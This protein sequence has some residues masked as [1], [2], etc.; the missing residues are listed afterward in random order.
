MLTLIVEVIRGADLDVSA[1]IDGSAVAI[2]G[3]TGTLGQALVT[4]LL[5]YRLNKIVIIS[6]S[7]SRQAAMKERWPESNDSPMRY[8][9]R[10]IRDKAGLLD[11]FEGVQIV[12]HAAALKRVEVCEREPIESLQTNVIGTLNACE[13]A[14]ECGVE[15]FM[16]ISSDKATAAA[17]YYG[18]LKYV[19]ERLVCLFNNYRGK[20]AIRYSACR[21]G[22]VLGST[23][24]V[25]HAFQNGNGVVQITDERCTRFWI[26]PEQAAKFV[27]S[28]IALSKGGE[29]FVP[30]M[31][32]MAIKDMARIIAPQSKVM[33][34]GL[35]GAEKIH[36]CLYSSEE[37][38]WVV[39]LE[40]R[41]VLLPPMP[42]WGGSLW[43][44]AK[45]VVEGSAYT[46]QNAPKL[47]KT[48]FLGMVNA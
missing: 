18:G 23:G 45:P 19:A 36:E 12:I 29:V 44:G 24:S 40:D 16:F 26:T 31:K 22:N 34:S 6:R 42:Y 3:G 33:V 32:A 41:F 17:V 5:Q 47:S 7:E 10:D 25:V 8:F 9:V 43:T 13:A 46:S 14:R 11:A 37:S 38:P 27:L 1:L 35:R 39:E 15:R 4:Q 21:Y 30:K 28:S 20:R 48:E 2:T